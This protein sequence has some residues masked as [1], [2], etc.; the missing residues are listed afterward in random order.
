MTAADG[1]SACTLNHL[2]FLWRAQEE[3][4]SALLC[5]TCEFVCHLSLALRRWNNIDQYLTPPSLS[6]ICTP[7][8]YPFLSSM[9]HSYQNLELGE[10]TSLSGRSSSG[11]NYDSEPS[12]LRQYRTVITALGAV[13]VVCI[14]GIAVYASRSTTLATAAGPLLS[15]STAEYDTAAVTLSLSEKRSNE[16]KKFSNE[17]KKSSGGLEI[18]AAAAVS[19]EQVCL[20]PNYTKVTLKLANEMTMAGLFP[21]LKGERKFEA[22][23][24]IRVGNHYLVVYD[25]LYQI[26][27]INQQLDFHSSAN[28]LLNSNP[29]RSG[30][31]G[32]EAIVYDEPT[33]TFYVVIEAELDPSSDKFH[34]A[35]IASAASDQDRSKLE[36]SPDASAGQFHATIEEVEFHEDSKEYKLKDKCKTEFKFIS[37][38]KGFEGAAH[39]NQ[40]DEGGIVFMGLCEGNFWYVHCDSSCFLEFA[41][42]SHIALFSHFQRGWQTWSS[43]RQRTHRSHAQARRDRLRALRLGDGLPARAAEAGCVRGLL[44]SRGST[45]RRR[46]ERLPHRGDVTGIVPGV[47]G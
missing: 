24:V 44:R 9:S 45:D 21:D 43:S 6:S 20:D 28:E 12:L 22:S 35:N 46:E 4:E 27:K 31:S 18:S 16:D 13:A 26:G 34:R 32:F 47:A 1:A 23:D 38:N 2:M 8:R 41:G 10:R 40:G 7:C 36:E 15:S 33:G 19:S 3:S 29:E 14:V 5:H 17:D 42:D 11:S 39:V 37:G 25:N 30:D